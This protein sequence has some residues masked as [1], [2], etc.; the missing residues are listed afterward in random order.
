MDIVHVHALTHPVPEA[1][2][3]VQE[4]PIYTGGGGRGAG[5]LDDH[6]V[7]TE[8]CPTDREPPACAT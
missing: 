4:S 7:G 5:G 3:G 6:A 8:I 2:A 1:Q